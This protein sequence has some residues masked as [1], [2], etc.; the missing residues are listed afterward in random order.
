VQVAKF[1]K[2]QKLRR[3]EARERARRTGRDSHLDFRFTRFHE[4][5]LEPSTDDPTS[6]ALATK[7]DDVVHAELHAR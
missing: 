6:D 2:M 3:E 5:G 1:Q 7:P 4:T